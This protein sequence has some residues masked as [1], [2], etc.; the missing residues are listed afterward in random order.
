MLILREMRR[1]ARYIV[2]AAF[3]AVVVGYFTYH[4]VQG[5]KGIHSYLKINREV[6][7][8]QEHLKKIQSVRFELEHR[9]KGLRDTSLDLDLLEERARVVLNLMRDDELLIHFP[10][11]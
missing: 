9:V 3:C 6:R 8:A 10:N 2:P 11:N 4:S 1:R 5:D 7:D